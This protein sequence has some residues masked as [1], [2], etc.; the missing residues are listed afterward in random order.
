VSDLQ[1]VALALITDVEG[2]VLMVRQRGGPFSGSWLLPGGRREGAESAAEAVVREVREETGVGLALA[3][4]AAA[5]EVRSANFGAVLDVFR[6]T[7]ATGTLRAEDGSELR[8]VAGDDHV[9]HPTVRRVLLDAGLLGDGDVV[10]DLDAAGIRMRR[11]KES[12]AS[13]AAESA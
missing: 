3:E 8:W 1:R 11:L 12:V 6:G 7:L 4:W 9:V 5:Y 2:R 13:E 10:R